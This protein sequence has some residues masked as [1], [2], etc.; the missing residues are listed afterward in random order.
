VN[1]CIEATR[2]GGSV[3]F[4]GIKDGDFIIPRFSRMIVK[5]LTIHNIIGRQIF[6]TW[7]T[8]QRVLSDRTNGVQDKMWQIILKEGNGTI[9]PLSQ[10]SKELVEARMNEHP[11]ILF[12][13]QK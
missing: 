12:D 5:G 6:K 11:K 7:Q 4:F 8:A 13:M 2:P 10:F 1:N 9:I 3:I